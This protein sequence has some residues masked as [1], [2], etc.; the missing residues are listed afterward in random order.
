M[1]EIQNLSIRY[2]NILAVDDVTLTLPAGS[3]TLLTGASGCGKSTLARAITGI[4]PHARP[5]T[6][7][8]SLRV[9]GQETREQSLPELAR[10]VVMVFQNPASQLFH[11][12]V[13]EDV[14]FGPR[15]LGLD[16]AEVQQRV[17]WALDV[18]GIASLRHRA[19]AQLSGGQQQLVAIASALAMR[20]HMLVLD[21]PT[22][23]LDVRHSRMVLKTLHRLH[24][25]Q[26]MTIL[27]IEHRFARAMRYVDRVL[28]MDAGRVVADGPP[29]TVLEQSA[30]QKRL[31]LRQLA[32]EP[33]RPWAEIIQSAPPP[34]RRGAPVLSLEH[35]SAGYHARQPVIQE[36]SL[37]IYAGEW[38]ALVGEN[39]AGKSTLG[40]VAAGLLRPMRGQ[41]RVGGHKRPTPGLDVAMLFQNPLD[42]L[43]TERVRDE[44]AFG[45]ENFGRDAEDEVAQA[46][47]MADLTALAARHPLALSV[48][49]QQRVT[50]AACAVLRPRLL[51]LDEPTLGQDWGHLQQ[52]MHALQRLHRAGSA[53]LLISHDYKLLHHYTQRV[54]LMQN[55]RIIKEGRLQ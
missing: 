49:Q 35:V 52:L 25:E 20:P 21:E 27:L 4:L 17:D 11:L 10:Q 29:T 1:I 43:F 50:L 54:L 42:Q 14:A 51:I 7:Q 26:G 18:V 8:G 53:I 13:Q 40:R 41:V 36:A 28:V 34:T 5:A 12:T 37:Q 2:G 47:R 19:P 46:L 33:P 30:L 44:V 9:V 55:G 23:S 24:N 38:V 31:G 15:N 3:F 22:A 16:E 32:D 48:G 6:L 45:P 39:G